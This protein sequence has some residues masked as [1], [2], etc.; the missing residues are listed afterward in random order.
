METLEMNKLSKDFLRYTFL[1]MLICWGICAICSYNGVWLEENYFLYI[2]YLFGGWSP[3]IAS[4]IALKKNKEVINFRDWLKNVFDFK[5]NVKS[6]LMVIA[7]VIVYILPLSLISGCEKETPLLT[8]IVMTP[9]MIPVMIILGGL[10]E[11]GWRYILQPELEKKYKFVISALIVSVIWWVWHLP[12]QFAQ[13][14]SQYGQDYWTF[15]LH[16]LLFGMKVLG[17]TFA[18]ASIRRITNSVWLCILFHGI[19]NALSGVYLISDNFGGSIVSTIIL[20]SSS[21]LLLRINEKKKIPQ[22][23]GWQ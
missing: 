19:M 18:L 7:L 15:G 16:F 1:I 23:E 11:A 17:I 8:V 6:Y 12:L 10:E 13:G 14:V 21:L 2:P 22:K 9:I 3:T 20:I 5:H 4:F